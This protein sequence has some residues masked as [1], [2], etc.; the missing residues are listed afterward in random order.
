MLDLATV[1]RELA[2]AESDVVAD[3]WISP[4]ASARAL[5]SEGASS[6]AKDVSVVVRALER[7]SGPDEKLDD[8]AGGAK[9]GPWPPR[10]WFLA[11]DK[12]TAR[13]VTASGAEPLD[14]TIT[15]VRIVSS[16]RTWLK[17][18]ATRWASEIEIDFRAVGESKSA[19]DAK[20]AEGG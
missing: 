11:L 19:A 17:P 9:F 14:G 16:E 18:S 7:Q 8:L 12:G 2:R 20:K 4:G 3:G 10:L 6:K 5:V 1:L 13:A 15:A